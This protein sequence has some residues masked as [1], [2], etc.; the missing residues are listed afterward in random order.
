MSPFSEFRT[1]HL[2][3]DLVLTVDANE[4]ERLA[5]GMSQEERRLV[6]AHL[7]AISNVL[8]RSSRR[9]VRDDPPAASPR[10]E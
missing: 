6:V 2:A 8:I 10:D 5:E 7:A 1:R 9:H 4:L 3:S